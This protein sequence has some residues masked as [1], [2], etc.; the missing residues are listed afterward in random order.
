MR[1]YQIDVLVE[2]LDNSHLRN[3]DVK[4]APIAR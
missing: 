3:A 2:K 1:H 4:E